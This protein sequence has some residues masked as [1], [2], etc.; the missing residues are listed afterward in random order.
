[1]VVMGGVSKLNEMVIVGRRRPVNGD[2]RNRVFVVPVTRG[3]SSLENS[4]R[5]KHDSKKGDTEKSLE[6]PSTDEADSVGRVS[7]L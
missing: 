3:P 1:M 5:P 2:T 6:H 4:K 7:G